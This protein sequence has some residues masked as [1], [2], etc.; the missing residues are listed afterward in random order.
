MSKKK[1]KFKYGIKNMH[2]APITEVDITKADGNA[3]TYGDWF[4]V[5]GAQSTNLTNQFASQ[6]I[7][8]DDSEYATLGK[9]NGYEGDI[10]VTILP[11]E[12]YD[13]ILHCKNG[14]LSSESPAEFAVAFEFDGDI[15]K[16]RRCLFHC[17]LTKLPNIVHNTKTDTLSIDSDTISIRAKPRL[18][19]GQII[20]TA[21]ED[22]E[23]YSKFFDA[24]PQPSEFKAPT[25]V[26]S[27]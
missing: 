20:G 11:P 3:Y 15:N 13:K 21:Y 18:D 7:Y 14:V 27:V 2:I 1:N 24:V 10:Q 23:I 9:N 8:A 19:D 25:E 6:S 16:G 12:F 4:G 22:W 17:S 5:P 26:G